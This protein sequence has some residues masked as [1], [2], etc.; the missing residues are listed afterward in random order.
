[1]YNWHHIN[2]K[3]NI[4]CINNQLLFWD[5]LY[6]HTHI[7]TR[8]R[9]HARNTMYSNS[10]DL[11]LIVF[12]INQFYL[13]FF[14]ILTRLCHSLYL[15]YVIKLQRV[16]YCAFL[17]TISAVERSRLYN[18]LIE[19][20]RKQNQVSMT[21]MCTITAIIWNKFFLNCNAEILDNFR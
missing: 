18:L 12:T 5:L 10:S 16:N 21:F 14:T 19:L 9:T 11:Q 3:W 4:I 6:C 2:F 13:L 7:H 15:S 1:M 20:S 17:F 8:A